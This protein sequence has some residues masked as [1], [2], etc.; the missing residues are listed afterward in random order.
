[1]STLYKASFG[2]WSNIL[3]GEGPDI[4]TP[5]P[6]PGPSPGPVVVNQVKATGPG[7]TSDDL[8]T[9]PAYP[10]PV[11]S[12]SALAEG[13]DN[14]TNNC[15]V[16]GGGSC[17]DYIKQQAIAEGIDPNYALALA[18]IE[19]GGCSNPATCQSGV[20]A[21]G[22]IQLMPGTARDVCGITCS[23]MSDAQVTEYLK[24]PTNN[25][26]L[27]VDY[28]AQS[29]DYVDAQMRA[30]PERF[31]ADRKNDY[32]AAYYNGG[33]AALEASNDCGSS[34]TKYECGINPGGYTETQTYVEKM[35]TYVNSVDSGTNLISSN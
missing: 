10:G 30:H 22:V 12:D 31:D 33:P 4:P 15:T 17:A 9:K 20:G 1:M 29:S 16:S 2:T 35:N 32:M 8:V 25:I 26:E 14:L 19:S 13:L 5:P 27:G 11:L 34:M 6:S 3:C 18:A 24:N 23:N 28:M 21:V 7:Y